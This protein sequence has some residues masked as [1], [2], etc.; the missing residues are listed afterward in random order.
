MASALQQIQDWLTSLLLQEKHRDLHWYSHSFNAKVL[1]SES[2]LRSSNIDFMVKYRRSS[3]SK[4][5]WNLTMTSVDS[6]S[7]C[8][9]D[10]IIICQQ[11]TK[12]HWSPCLWNQNDTFTH[13][14]TMVNNWLFN[15]LRLFHTGTSTRCEYSQR[16]LARALAANARASVHSHWRERKTRG[17]CM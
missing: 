16:V 1:T 8:I 17:N 3:Y 12:L 6:F 14:T 13:T 7:H 10:E 9:R 2:D 15:L 5:S 11:T 4:Y